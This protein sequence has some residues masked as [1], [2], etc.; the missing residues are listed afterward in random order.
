MPRITYRNAAG[1]VIPGVTTVL[2]NLGWN[3][4]ALMHWAWK[5]GWEQKD[6]KVE[7]RTAADIGTVAHKLIEIDVT[8]GLIVD[9]DMDMLRVQYG[10]EIVEK[11]MTAY[12]A[13]LRWRDSHSFQSIAAEESMISERLQCGGTLDH[14]MALAVAYVEDKMAILD[15]K[16]TKGLY[17]EHLIQVATYA[18]MRNE[19]HPDSPIEEL[20]WLKL[21][22]EEPSFAHEYLPFDCDKVRAA[23]EV[24]EHLRAL[25]DLKRRMK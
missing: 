24:F 12:E 14:R 13:W 9:D 11:A 22:K 20:H 7:K 4:R 1:V 15:V 16:V 25:H 10:A 21:G 8:Q 23:I 19:N 3:R 17:P 18:S 5:Q 2:D 6:Y